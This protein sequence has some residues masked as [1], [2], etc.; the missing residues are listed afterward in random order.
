M[1]KP[2][3]LI[4]L[5]G[6][7]H[8]QQCVQCVRKM[9]HLM[10]NYASKTATSTPVW[11]QCVISLKRSKS[12]LH[13]IVMRVQCVRNQIQDQA[14]QLV[15]K[16]LHMP[17]VWP[18]L[19][20][21]LK[22]ITESL[23]VPVTVALFVR[24]QIQLPASH[25]VVKIKTISLAWP[26]NANG[27]TV[28]SKNQMVTVLCAQNVRNQIQLQAILHAQKIQPITHAWT[29]PAQS[30]NWKRLMVLVHLVQHVKLLTQPKTSASKIHL[31]I[32]N[33]SVKSVT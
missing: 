29:L 15:F 12:L 18:K 31:P 5:A 33:A 3:K 8:H 21:I 25:L 4:A 26:S 7:A 9:P 19:A 16:I 6:T 2:A 32:T 20:I 27:V 30:T 1:E 11:S 10:I 24:N 14:S 23:T 22:D 13:L 28:N 17:H